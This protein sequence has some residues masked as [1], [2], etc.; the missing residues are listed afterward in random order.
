MSCS[1]GDGPEGAV[2][3]DPAAVQALR[4]LDD[5]WQVVMHLRRATNPWLDGTVH[6]LAV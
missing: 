6:W 3:T 1:L 4:R 5:L 2:W